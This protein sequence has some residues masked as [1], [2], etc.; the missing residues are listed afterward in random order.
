MFFFCVNYKKRKNFYKIELIIK[1]NCH[2]TLMISS[3]VDLCL[4][5]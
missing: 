4:L 5:K 1:K 3:L 2:K